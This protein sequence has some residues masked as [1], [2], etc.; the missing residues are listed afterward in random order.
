MKGQ[1]LEEKDWLKVAKYRNGKSILSLPSK[2][3]KVSPQVRDRNG[4]GHYW[5]HAEVMHG[6]FSAQSIHCF[7]LRSITEYFIHSTLIL[8]P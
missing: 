5:M 1:F 4:M 8:L 3:Q 7:V 6:S 2:S